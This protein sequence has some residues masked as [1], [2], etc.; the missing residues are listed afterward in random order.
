M[1]YILP[2]AEIIAMLLQDK[3]KKLLED[4]VIVE[5][6]MTNTL[7]E[8]EGPMAALDGGKIAKQ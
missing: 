8:G 1:W 5:G 7:D 3:D 6:P 2:A 4:A